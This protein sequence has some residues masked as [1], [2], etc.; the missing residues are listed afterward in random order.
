M[1]VNYHYPGMFLIG[2]IILAAVCLAAYFLKRKGGKQI[3]L[4][5][6]NTERLKN[7]PIYKKNMQQAR[8]FRILSTCGIIL[9]LIASLF[10]TARPFRRESLKDTVSRRD[11]FLCI[12]LSSSNSAGVRELTE[13]FGRTIEGLEGDRIG[14]SLFN[15]SSIRYVPM[16]DDYDFA[17]RRLDALTEYLAAEEE[18]ERD[19]ANKY[20]SVYDIPD[21]ERE[22][23]DEL[24][25]T[26]SSFDQG[27]TAGYEIK[28]TSAVGEGLASCLFSFPELNTEKRT[29]IIIFLTDNHEELLDAPLVTL[30]ESARMCQTDEVT[31]F[32]IYPGNGQDSA[33][34]ASE[35]SG[36]KSA[37]EL[38][39]GTFYESGTSLTAQEILADIASKEI[40]T[41]DTVT[42]VPDTDTPFFWFCVLIAGFLLIAGTTLFFV[43][44][45]G[46]R[47]G[48]FSRKLTAGI[49]L[50]GMLAGIIVIGIRPVY[51][52]PS[53]EVM[54]SNLDVVFAV[55]TT[56]SMWAEDHGKGTRLD[57]VKDDIGAIMNALPGSSFSVIRF[58]NGAEILTPF[59]QDISAIDDIVDSLS[60]PAYTTAKGS[61]LNTSY[62]DLQAILESSEKKGEK[63]RRIVFLFS[64]GETTDGSELRSFADLE[65][66]VDDGAVLGYGTES[67][68]RMYY[69]GRGYVKDASTGTD[70][71]SCID[72]SAL[73]SIA[74]DLGISYIYETGEL[75]A[76]GVYGSALGKRLQSIRRM[77]R[78]ALIADG[79]RTG[80]EETYHY[81]A[82]FTGVL[83]LI[84]LFLTIYR[85]GV[86]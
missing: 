82:A 54:T 79:D 20:E 62:E 30:E 44:R 50:A 75:D 51:M 61:S 33:D 4:R 66:L 69:E 48:V 1:G 12:D 56:I 58:D 36:M 49:L 32:G 84:W 80:C 78:D 10:L 6:A 64:D 81:F 59:T 40:E 2:G 65:N 72:E 16:T 29:R 34:A 74:D 22:R 24:N 28:G 31:V 45:R 27:I 38:T 85:G 47:R 55:D 8:I 23:Y 46:V 3:T 42:A 14:I 70:A 86:A 83:L 18:F 73:R 17:L 7:N 41:T 13:E 71:R 57:G 15:T 19:F 76:T 63:R 52:S 25:R 77:S 21:S 26:L 68:G 67:G 35:M 43:L 11:I 39:G 60:M 5:V 37:V 9:A 53:A